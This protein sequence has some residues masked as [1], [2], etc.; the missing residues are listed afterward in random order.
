[1]GA[2]AVTIKR[3]ELF[4]ET[5][6]QYICQSRKTNPYS[7]WLY[8]FGLNIIFTTYFIGVEELN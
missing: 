3:T 4:Q 2:I 8:S 5:R 7:L 6:N 1:M